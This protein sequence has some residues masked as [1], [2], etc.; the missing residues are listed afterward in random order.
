MATPGSTT[1]R[2]YGWPHQQARADAI[3]RMRDGTPCTRC[4]QPM[5]RA[6]SKLIDL[7]HTDDRAGYRGLAHARCNRQAGQAKGV[8]RRRAKRSRA[9]REQQPQRVVNSRVW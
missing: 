7:D 5:H 3:K 4:G 8:A 9:R 2:G 1:A 6:E